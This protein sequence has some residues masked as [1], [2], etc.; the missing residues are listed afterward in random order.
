[1]KDYKVTLIKIVRAEVIVSSEDS[2]GDEIADKAW[3]QF[4]SGDSKIREYDYSTK[5][6]PM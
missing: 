1:M 4:N 3:E 2:H 6:E 5:I